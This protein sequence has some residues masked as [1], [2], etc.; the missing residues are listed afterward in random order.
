VATPDPTHFPHSPDSTWRYTPET[1]EDLLAWARRKYSAP[2]LQ[3][4]PPNYLAGYTNYRREMTRKLEEQRL[5]RK[6]HNQCTVPYCDQVGYPLCSG[7]DTPQSD[8]TAD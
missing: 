3:K 5:Y 7:H 6:H 8:P 1:G 4:L 2:D